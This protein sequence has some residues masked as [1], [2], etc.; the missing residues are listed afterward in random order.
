LSLC[1]YEAIV[2]I[3]SRPSHKVVKYI[4][5]FGSELSLLH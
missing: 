3:P 1:V 2:E 4:V 5:Q